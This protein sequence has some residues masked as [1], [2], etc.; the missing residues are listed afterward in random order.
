M[1]LDQKVTETL[2][3]SK[4]FAQSLIKNQKILVNNK[5]IT[6]NG[7]MISEEDHIEIEQESYYVSRG[8]YKLLDA[9]HHFNI[10]LQEKI[11]GDIGASTGGFS[12]V[13]LEKGAK[14]IYAIDV[15]KNQLHPTILNNNKVI[16]IEQYNCRYMQ[17]ND[18]PEL[19]DFACMDVSFISIQKI[20]PSL[21]TCLSKN[22]ELVILIKPQFEVGKQYLNKNGIVT[23]EKAVLEMLEQQKLFFASLNLTLIQLKKCDLIGKTGNQEYLAYLKVGE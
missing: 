3:C 21:I 15:G 6:K 7:Y 23:S 18:F 17:P 4:T 14:V 12:Q 22:A 8:A 5:I 10:H 13:L 11:C 20:L 19:F 1:R 16:A 9:I 2:N